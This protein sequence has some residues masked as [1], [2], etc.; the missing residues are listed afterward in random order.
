MGVAVSLVT[1]FAAAHRS[2]FMGDH[3]RR[4]RR[5]WLTEMQNKLSGSALRMSVAPQLCVCSTAHICVRTGE[6]LHVFLRDLARTVGF[7][8]CALSLLL[9]SSNTLVRAHDKRM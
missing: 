2:R 4:S 8:L 7:F 3:S 6:A 9:A 5:R 1:V